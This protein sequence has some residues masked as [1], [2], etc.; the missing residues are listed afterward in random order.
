MLETVLTTFLYSLIESSQQFV[1]QAYI[2]FITT[3]HI[4]LKKLP[5]TGQLLHLAQVMMIRE[6]LFTLILDLRSS[7]LCI[8][9]TIFLWPNLLN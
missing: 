6:L 5:G 9:L 1:R 7:T 2:I 8:L 4:L 3:I